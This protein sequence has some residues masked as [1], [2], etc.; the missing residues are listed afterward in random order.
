MRHWLCCV[1]EVYGLNFI[2]VCIEIGVTGV[3]YLNVAVVV[4]G[5]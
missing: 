5:V 4:I 1:G 3:C 2:T